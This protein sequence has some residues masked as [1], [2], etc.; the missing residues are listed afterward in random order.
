[1]SKYGMS[2]CVLGWAAEFAEF[3]IAANA[4]WP[5]TLIAT[6]ATYAWLNNGVDIQ[7]VTRHFRNP[8]IMADAAYE[9]IRRPSRDRPETF[10]R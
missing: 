8:E 3:G 2:M 5:R 1:M 10:Y 4:L 9:I 6:S 7:E